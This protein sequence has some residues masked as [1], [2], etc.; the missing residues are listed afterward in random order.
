MFR[1]IH[2]LL[3]FFP[4]V[5]WLESTNQNTHSFLYTIAVKRNAMLKEYTKLEVER[6]VGSWLIGH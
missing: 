4:L 5:L 2:K 6:A 3:S 1:I